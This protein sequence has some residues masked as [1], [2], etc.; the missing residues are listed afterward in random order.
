MKRLWNTNF[1]M[2]ERLNE[3][4]KLIVNMTNGDYAYILESDKG[5]TRIVEAY[6]NLNLQHG[7][8]DKLNLIL[9]SKKFKTLAEIKKNVHFSMLVKCSGIQDL[10]KFQLMIS[11]ESNYY[12]I[13]LSTN[14]FGRGINLIIKNKLEELRTGIK[15][16]G[17]KE[18]VSTKE[19][20]VFE[21]IDFPILLIYRTG[22]IVFANQRLLDLFGIQ[23]LDS[24]QEFF[25]NTQFIDNNSNHL[26]YEDLPFYKTIKEHKSIETEK[27]KFVNSAGLEKWLSFNSFLLNESNKD[28]SGCFIMDIS[29][30]MEEEINLKET[31]GSIQ[32]LLY[33]TNADGSE[34]YFITDAVRNLFGFTPEELYNNKLLILRTIAKEHFIEFRKFIDKLRSGEA[35]SIEYRMKDRFGKEHWVRHTGT[36]LIRNGNVHK[37]VGMIHEITD[38]KITQLKLENSEQKFRMLIDTAEDLIFILNGFGYISMVNKNGANSLGF[39]PEEMIG[40]H[41]LDFIDKDDE[42]K[43]VNAL[44]KVL[45]TEEITSFET[46]F[47]DRFEKGISFEINAKPFIKGG[48]V[49]GMI[50]IGRNI[51]NR[52]HDEHKIRELNSKLIEANRIISIERERARQKINVLEELHK[53]KSEFISNISHELRTPL[54]SVVGFAETIVSDPDLPKETIKE[55]SEIILSEGKR[56]AKLIN[57]VLDFSKLESGEDEIR[58]EEVGIT[59]ILDE[60]TANYENQIQQKQIHLSK[61]F[62]GFEIVISADTRRISQVF[63]NLI[64]NAVKYTKSGGRISLLINNYDKEIEVVVSDTGVGIP[65]KE[66]PKLFQRFTKIYNPGSPVSGAGFGLAV[67]K[68]IIDLHKGYIR[69]QSELDKGTTFIIRLPKKQFK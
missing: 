12:L 32:S 39:M 18:M 57:D 33:S 58:F 40:K 8:L 67:V 19:L 37:I 50:S 44:G 1:F 53:L 69:V 16:I 23:N 9:S 38:E 31:F 30:E 54:A 43:V 7:G 14:K 5:K 20:S 52:K 10:K 21:N 66:I 55:F 6:G 45:Q 68:Q 27:I 4:L 65:E 41:F 2:A 47:I 49:S 13:L 17:K 64:S 15:Q 26:K 36:P 56:L 62:P 63:N 59:K 29:K 24:L 60:V 48:E 11:G 51:T 42:T 25:E 22:K 35:A 34:Y 46:V 28:Y 61:E 3:I